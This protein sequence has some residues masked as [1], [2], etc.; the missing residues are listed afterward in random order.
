MS[1]TL[2]TEV[3]AIVPTSGNDKVF[4]FFGKASNGKKFYGFLESVQY[5]LFGGQKMVDCHGFCEQ[6]W[7][8]PFLVKF[9][10][11]RYNFS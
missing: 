6:F 11:I 1:L 3:F 7:G 8:R 10:K 4:L 5:V 9:A 2:K